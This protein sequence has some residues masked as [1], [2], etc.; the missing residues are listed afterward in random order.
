ML[1]REKYLSSVLSATAHQSMKSHQTE[2]RFAIIVQLCFVILP[3]LYWNISGLT[4]STNI[5]EWAI[6]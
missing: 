3:T 4:V 2:K 1:L 6:P 5:A